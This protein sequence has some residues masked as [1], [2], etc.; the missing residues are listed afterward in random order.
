MF[1]MLILRPALSL[2]TC[3]LNVASALS[4][5]SREGEK[6][7]NEKKKAAFRKVARRWLRT[8]W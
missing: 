5:R 1:T 6:H 2:S 8:V 7:K 3:V 4:K